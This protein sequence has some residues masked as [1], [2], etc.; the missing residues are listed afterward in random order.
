M[1]EH[2]TGTPAGD[3]AVV[4]PAHDEEQR[5]SATVEAARSIA[6]VDLVV[7]VDD[8]STDDTAGLARAAGAVVARHGR[9][10]G[11]AGA[12]ETGAAVVAAVDV[13]EGRSRPRHLLFLDADLE[14]TAAAGAP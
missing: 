1:A 9:N 10:R 13:R 14:R 5:V 4:I 3:T 7:V 8:G 12:M 6:G 2:T 11:K